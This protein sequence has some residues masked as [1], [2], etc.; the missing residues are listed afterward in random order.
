MRSC[1]L[2][3]C[4]VA[5][6]L[7]QGAECS[8]NPSSSLNKIEI[9][10]SQRRVWQAVGLRPRNHDSPSSFELSLPF[11]S[12]NFP[13][14]T[15]VFQAEPTDSSATITEDLPFNFVT[16]SATT[17]EPFS[18]TRS[19]SSAITTKASTATLSPSRTQAPQIASGSSTSSIANQSATASGSPTPIAKSF[20]MT[21]E[22]IAATVVLCCFFFGGVAIM[23]YI[24]IRRN[25]ASRKHHQGPSS[26]SHGN[27]GVRPKSV[28]N[29]LATSTITPRESMMYHPEHTK[30]NSTA[31]LV[32]NGWDVSVAE[33]E[34]SSD[35]R[36]DR[37][38]IPMS[39][40]EPSQEA[41]RSPVSPLLSA[42][43][44]RPL[45]NVSRQSE[46]QSLGRK[47]SF[48][49]VEE[50][51]RGPSQEPSLNRRSA[52]SSNPPSDWPLVAP[53]YYTRVSPSP[54]R[55]QRQ[56]NSATTGRHSSGWQS[57]AQRSS[58][59]EIDNRGS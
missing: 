14:A 24:R 17:D 9:L 7:C 8:R 56:G 27:Y 25:L 51:A 55:Q 2:L 41:E 49:N 33:Q 32:K 43:L 54:A 50:G 47:F 28:G 45:S 15:D 38:D 3:H 46:R 10:P 1:H 40:I 34:P 58:F 12:E 39:E 53:N 35:Y 37:T 19:P 4:L 57:I 18:T 23:L 22:A 29:S 42:N 21:A 20:H 31:T 13:S 48:D 59:E 30:S 26:D 6:W 52:L 44:P 5:T 16:S 11:Q 36:T